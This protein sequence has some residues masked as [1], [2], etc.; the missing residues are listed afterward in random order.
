MSFG[1]FFSRNVFLHDTDPSVS[2]TTVKTSLY[3]DFTIVFI[4]DER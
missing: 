1:F 3:D 2:N 4:V